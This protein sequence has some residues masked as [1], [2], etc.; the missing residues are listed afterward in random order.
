MIL[1]DWGSI[2]FF[3]KEWCNI[4]SPWEGREKYCLI[5]D[6]QKNYKSIVIDFSNQ[7]RKKNWVGVITSQNKW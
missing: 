5:F 4:L 3:L 1:E 6:W 2:L 7:E